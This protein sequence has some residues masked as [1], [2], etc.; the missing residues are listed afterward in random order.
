VPGRLWRG[1]GLGARVDH[2]AAGQEALWSGST[3]P[4]FLARVAELHGLPAPRAGEPYV[5][6]WR[7][8]RK[9]KALDFSSAEAFLRCIDAYDA[10]TRFADGELERLYRA[11]EDLGLPGRPL[12]V[13]TSD[14]GEGLASHGIA[15]HGG[16]VFQEQLQVPLVLHATDDSL[17]PR[18]VNDLVAHVDLF[19]TLAETL[20]ARVRGVEPLYE[21]RSLWPLARGTGVAGART[22]FGQRRPAEGDGGDAAEGEG[23]A[24]SVYALQD[25]RHKLILHEPGD[26]LFFDLATDPRELSDLGTEHAAAAEL[27][28]A[29]ELR[30]R[31]FAALPAR[32][33]EP[34]PEHWLEELRELGYV[35]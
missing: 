29:L 14:H 12:W 18:V 25:A 15:G 13:V 35:R 2:V 4:D 19:P 24:G 30:L 20:G 21:A 9:G 11:I 27:R 5:V 23:G 22:V 33:E 7:I 3:P 1:N 8:E 16:H 28:A 6:D 26:D 34:V 10:L 31:A 32:A 17:S